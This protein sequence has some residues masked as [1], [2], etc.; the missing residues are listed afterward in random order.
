MRVMGITTAAAMSSTKTPRIR[1]K[2]HRGM[3][4]HLR[5]FGFSGFPSLLLGSGSGGTGSLEIVVFP[6]D[7]Q[8]R[9][10]GVPIDGDGNAA[11][12]SEIEFWR[13]LR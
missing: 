7:C 12:I 8:R 3:P 4:Q 10:R 2:I 1:R 6:V 9:D 11:R 13:E 5:R